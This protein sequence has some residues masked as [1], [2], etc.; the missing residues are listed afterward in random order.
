MREVPKG[1]QNLRAVK[2]ADP[3]HLEE[4]ED[5]TIFYD[6]ETRNA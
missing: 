6:P 5:F 2:F 1:A 4:A 3:H